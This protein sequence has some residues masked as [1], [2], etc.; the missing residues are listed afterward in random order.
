MN[1]SET[2]LVSNCIELWKQHD[3]TLSENWDKKGQMNIK[4]DLPKDT[5]KLKDTSFQ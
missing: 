2:A 1:F 5:E 4:F 3:T